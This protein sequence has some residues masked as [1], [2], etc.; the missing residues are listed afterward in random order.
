[1]IH[2]GERVNVIAQQ[3]EL[4]MDMRIPWGCHIDEVI[5][6]IRTAAPDADV[7]IA[8]SKDPS[9]SAPGWLSRLVCEGIYSAMQIT[10]SP[11]VT[12]AASDARYLRRQGAE[13]VVYG[14]GDLNL[15]HSVNEN[16]PVSMLNN[17]REVY[18]YVLEKMHFS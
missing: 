10:A 2:G 15:L 11:G 16:V 17:C 1:M 5:T 14:P 3:C 18:R 12:Q 13:V 8:E 6:A 7:T 9:I 4:D